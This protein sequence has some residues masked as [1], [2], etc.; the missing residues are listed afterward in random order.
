MDQTYPPANRLHHGRDYSRAFNRQQKAAGRWS[1]LLV[2]PRK[3]EAPARLGI[4]VAVKTVKLAVRRHQIKRWAREL[5]RCE[6]KA[7]LTGHDAV[8]LLRAD[9]PDHAA[10]AGELRVLLPKALHATS[11]PRPRG[12]RR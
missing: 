3:P 4:M 2:M 5:F 9:P 1:V 8:V 10:F 6:W 12:P 11:Q 7:A